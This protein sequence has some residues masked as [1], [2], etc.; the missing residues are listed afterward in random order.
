MPNNFDF[1]YKNDLKTENITLNVIITSFF[2]ASYIKT[3]F[4]KIYIM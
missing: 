2:N 4:Y 3:S 1:F